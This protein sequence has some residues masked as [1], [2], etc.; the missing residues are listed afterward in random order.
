MDSSSR[1]MKSEWDIDHKTTKNDSQ[2]TKFFIQSETYLWNQ[3]FFCA[4]S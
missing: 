2:G 3:R 1:Q 4:V